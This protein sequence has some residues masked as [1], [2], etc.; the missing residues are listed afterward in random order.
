MREDASNSE[1][2]EHEGCVSQ[3]DARASGSKCR[4]AP[5]SMGNAH[6]GHDGVVGRFGQR[7]MAISAL[8][9]KLGPFQHDMMYRMD[10]G[11]RFRSGS[12]SHTSA[13]EVSGNRTA[14][15]AAVPRCG[16]ALTG[17]NSKICIVKKES[18]TRDQGRTFCDQIVS[19]HEYTKGIQEGR[20][21]TLG[22]CIVCNETMY[23][24]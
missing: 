4:D 23:Y 6:A 5:C 15:E 13:F 12:H 20:S 8:E 19:W 7:H 10:A 24:F 22:S 14:A 2:L 17:F 18:N 21:G 9:K 11:G 1:W 3:E 16:L